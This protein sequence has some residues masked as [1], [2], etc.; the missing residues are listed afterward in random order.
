M[1][2]SSIQTRR[3]QTP[4]TLNVIEAKELNEKLARLLASRDE[5]T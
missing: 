2:A 3:Q 5:V 4:P 1:L